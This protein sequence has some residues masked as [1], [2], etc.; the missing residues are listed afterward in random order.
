MLK[1]NS[2]VSKFL[3][4]AFVALAFV[5]S[6]GTIEA[7]HFGSTT[8]K[9]GSKGEYVKAL[10]TLVGAIADG[11]FG[12]ATKAK[13]ATWQSVNGLTV[14]GAFGPMSM[15]KAHGSVSGN[16]PAGCSSASG[17]ST[18]TGLPCSSVNANTFAPSGC[19][20]ASGFSPVTGGACYAAGSTPTPTGGVEGILSNIVK[21][22]AYNSTK[23]SEATTDVKVLGIEVTAKDGDQKIDSLN[24]AFNN[25]NGSSSKKITKYASKI[26]VWL[27][28]VIIGTK[29]TSDFSD[30]ASDIYTYRF[31]GMN[32]VLKKDMKGQIIV[33]IDAV[34]SMDSTDATNETWTVFV[35]S[36]LGG[37]DDNYVSASSANGRFRDYGTA[38]VTSTIDFQKAGGASS[39]QKYKVNTSSTNPLANT[40]QVSRTSDTNGVTLLAV[41]VK[42]E[43]G[44]M[45]L[46]KFPVTLTS[47]S[48]GVDTAAP[49][50]EAIVKT[51]YLFANGVQIASES[52]PAGVGAL[53]LIF[54]NTSK[55]NYEI[56]SN[57]T[58]KFEVRA[59]LNDI[60]DTNV[61]AASCTA[62]LLPTVNCSAASTSGNAPTAGQLSTDF[63]EG[64]QI[65]AS[66]TTTNVTNTTVELNNANQD[67]VTN[68]SGSAAGELQTAR[69]TGGLVSMGTTTYAFTA[70]TSGSTNNKTIITIPVTVK[71]FDDTLYIGQTATAAL[72]GALANQVGFSYTLNN[73][74][75]PTT[76]VVV[77]PSG[78]TTAPTST[79]SSS[80]PV[81]G[82]AWRIDSGSTQTFNIQVTLSGATAAASMR[83]QMQDFQ[84]YTDAALTAG[85]VIQSLTP[86][87]SFQSVYSPIF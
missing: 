20:S 81:S 40:M 38:T 70:N 62:S 26:N 56:A 3:I 54:G 14:D 60:E 55:L 73:G 31:S 59:D 49:N 45:K 66:Y 27:D 53:T 18:T 84:F 33:S 83:V 72:T 19:T 86:M 12:P 9:V 69:S 58:V 47:T 15:A 68:R 41:D 10:Q 29:S 5:V 39:D 85:E 22:G 76:Q 8:L 64:D 67:S 50:V 78:A 74:T 30:D 2:K 25:A 42:A 79:V 52:A 46:Q 65:T 13:V 80:A 21:L 32:G 6:T 35:G 75:L 28:G 7:A 11:N 71:A 82:S 51:F 36:T 23:V 4:G 1:I 34:S 43:N 37:T 44:A 17:F 48:A 87:S 16:F 61:A 24:I 57:A 63:D 77:I